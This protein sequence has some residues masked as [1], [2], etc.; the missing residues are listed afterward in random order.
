MTLAVRYPVSALGEG[1]YQPLVS[2]EPLPISLEPTD[3]QSLRQGVTQVEH[4]APSLGGSPRGPIAFTDEFWGQ[5]SGDFRS[6][7]SEKS[8]VAR[9]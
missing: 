3:A 6:L 4:S 9:S 1:T 7:V 5:R 2:A 8:V